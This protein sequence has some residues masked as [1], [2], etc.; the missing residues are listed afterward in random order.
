[1]KT[2]ILAIVFLL[3]GRTASAGDLQVPDISKLD[4]AAVSALD[5]ACASWVMKDRADKLQSWMDAIGPLCAAAKNRP[6]EAAAE[7]VTAT[8]GSAPA[9]SSLGDKLR[10]LKALLDQGLITQEDYTRT[11]AKLLT[12]FAN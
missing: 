6:P 11:K 1:M 8:A 9:A 5:I 2:T 3:L 12:G 4:D 10:Q 7:P